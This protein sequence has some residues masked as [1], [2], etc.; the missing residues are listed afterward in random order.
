MTREQQRPGRRRTSFAIGITVVLI[1]AIGGVAIFRATTLR[2]LPD[3][4]DPFDVAKYARIDIPD[5]Q[6]SFTYY[7]RAHELFKKDEPQTMLAV[8]LDWSQ[9]DE[10]Q[11]RWLEANRDALNVW[12]EGTKCD[13][14]VYKQPGSINF[15]TMLP[16]V[17]SLRSVSRLANLEACRLEHEGRYA[18]SWSW[19]RA[20]LR[21]SRHLGKGAVIIERLVGIA[22]FTGT[23]KQAMHWADNPKIDAS[24]IRQALADVIALDAMT[25]EIAEAFRAE[26]FTCINTIARA[27]LRD[28]AIIGDYPD[29]PSHPQPT[30]RQKA[31]AL[32]GV[33]I[34]EP[35]RS[36]RVFRLIT[37]NQ[38]A[39]SKLSS[40]ERARRLVTFDKF[41]LYLPDQGTDSPI[42]LDD[43]RRWF[44]STRYAKVFSSSWAGVERAYRRDD[45]ARAALIVHL[46]EQLY[47]RERGELPERPEQLVGPFLKSLP[48]EYILPFDEATTAGPPR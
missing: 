15:E 13:R 2:G 17:Q 39:A 3:I 38:L 22:I 47:L 25:P 42:D 19:L 12:F 23:S 11:T 1:A 18:D 10:S 16:V 5:D 24:L 6:N 27:D 9:V 21:A 29:A 7:I 20:N 8:Y 40:T 14:G 26:Y 48:D 35:E 37:A 46:A 32:L 45:H 41:S 4:G 43:L 36:R 34:H 30:L 28:S 44:E 31:E 33:L